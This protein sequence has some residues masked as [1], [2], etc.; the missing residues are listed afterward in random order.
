MKGTVKSNLV[1]GIIVL[2]PVA[3]TL[4]VVLWVYGVVMDLPGA[5]RLRFTDSAVVNEVIQ[6][7]FTVAIIVVFLFVVGYVVRTT[8]GVYVKGWMDSTARKLPVIGF[9]YN[10][11]QMAVEAV[12]LGAEEFN[13]PVKIDF[14]GV[15]FTAFKTGGKTDGGREIIFVPTAPNITSGFVVEV[16]PDITEDAGESTEEALTRILSAGFASAGDEELPEH[17]G[18]F[19][20]FE[21][22]GSEE[23]ED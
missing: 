14:D 22:G 11:T 21:V 20:G 19:E 6:L 8:T 18:D 7:T 13:R 3:V 9:F 12:S 15:R 10:A 1:S 5:N 17:L 23:E 2:A 16:D 4:Y